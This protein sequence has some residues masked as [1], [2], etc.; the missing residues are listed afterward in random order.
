MTNALETYFIFIDSTKNLLFN[1]T[2]VEQEEVARHLLDLAR[3][4]EKVICIK[5]EENEKI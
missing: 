1:A 4:Q 3:E 5:E 2:T